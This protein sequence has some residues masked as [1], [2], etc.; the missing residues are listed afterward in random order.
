MLRAVKIKVTGKVQGVGFRPFIYSLSKK[1]KIKGTVQN[2]LDGV[3]IH[4][5]G[6]DDLVTALIDHIQTSPPYLAKVSEVIVTENQPSNYLEFTIIPSKRT[7]C[8]T[9]LIPADAAI[10]KD[11]LFDIK[12]PDNR[13]YR[14]PFTNCTQC[15]PRYTIIR[16]LP[17]DRPQT[18]MN[19]FQMCPSCQEEYEDPLNRRHHAQ[20]ICCPKCGPALTLYQSKKKPEITTQNSIQ[21]AARLLSA[22][23][24]LAIKGIGGYHLA[25]DAHNP[26]AIKELRKRKR[27]PQRPLAI[28]VKTLET[29]MKYCHVSE[30]EAGMLNIPEMPIVVLRK[31][32]TCGLPGILAPGISTLGVMLPYSPLHFLL[33]ETSRLESIV[34][35]S[36]NSS[37]FPLQYRDD[38]EDLGDFVLTHNRPILYPIDDSVIEVNQEGE[39]TFLRRARGFIP[40]VFTTEYPV[41]QILALGGNQKNTFAVGKEN[42][43]FMGPHI[44]DLENEEML[45]HYEYQMDHYIRWLGYKPKYIALDSHPAYLVNMAAKRFKGGVIPVQHHHAH[46]VSCMADNGLKEPC[47]GLIL[48]GTGYGE[49]G[50]IWG[51]ELMFGSAASCE[52]LAHL[53]YSPLPGGE[54]SIKEPWRNAAG[55]ILHYWPDQGRNLAEKLF[56]EK[57]REIGIIENMLKRKINTPLA[58]TCGRLFDAI[59]AILGICQTS[60]YEGE[61][62]IKLADY[63]FTE[64]T[65]NS[66]GH[67]SFNVRKNNGKPHQLDF[68]PMLYEIIQDH[69]MGRPLQTIIYKFHQTLVSASVHMILISAEEKPELNRQIVLSGGSFQ[70]K[71]LAQELSRQLTQNGFSVFTHKKVPCHDG[72]LSLG[73]IIVASHKVQ[74][75]NE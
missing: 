30:A 66:P 20:P 56:P 14:Y 46:H 57:K 18:S 62:A 5:E 23:K 64:Q 31:K 35:T 68:S 47:F 43:I 3:L 61:A 74:N 8:H 16:D 40:E 38:S 55:M 44:G 60:T 19:E 27:R 49:D 4:A 70:N 12:N 65:D 33:F 32:E 67:Y 37:G 72:G 51:F 10:C 41:D 45:L 7:G 42:S 21:E 22:G 36:S 63:M 73:Q 59:S 2:N 17:Y 25:C 28:M 54:K 1:Y 58:G 39:I 15:G 24:I 9:P 26:S 29:A 71:F 34:L 52:R 13:R 53:T 6:S 75:T 11:C 48:D 69:L 50:H